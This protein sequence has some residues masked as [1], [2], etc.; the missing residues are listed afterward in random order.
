MEGM[1][2]NLEIPSCV[3]NTLAPLVPN[4]VALWEE[5]D[6][7][8]EKEEGDLGGGLGPQLGGLSSGS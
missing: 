5:E 8:K 7:G 4:L 1:D 3:W 6:V 2:T